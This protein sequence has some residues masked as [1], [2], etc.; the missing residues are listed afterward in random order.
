[1]FSIKASSGPTFN[2]WFIVSVKKQPET[3]RGNVRILKGYRALQGYS[4][5]D[6]SAHGHQNRHQEVLPGFLK[7]GT[8]SVQP[9]GYHIYY[10]N[11]E[12]VHSDV[13]F[14][15]LTSAIPFAMDALSLYH[16]FDKLWLNLQSPAHGPPVLQNLS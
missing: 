15:G 8:K 2:I 13:L 4:S 7:E 14:H 11:R 1:M 5:Q 12:R 6:Q 3:H 9:M 16:S 10:K